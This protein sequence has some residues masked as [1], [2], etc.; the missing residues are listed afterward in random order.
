VVVAE[1]SCEKKYFL[2]GFPATPRET[3]RE[4][5]RNSLFQQFSRNPRGCCR[6]NV[7]LKKYFEKI[8]VVVAVK[9]VV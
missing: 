6:I 2:F 9:I 4:T 7:V 5:S 8:R 3:F 1:K